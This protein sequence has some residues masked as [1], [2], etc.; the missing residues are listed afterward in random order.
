MRD[1]SLAEALRGILEDGTAAGAYTVADPAATAALLNAA[2]HAFDPG[3]NGS[4]AP[5]DR[6]LIT[7][8]QQLFRRAAG[9]TEP[10]TP[11]L[12][13]APWLRRPALRRLPVPG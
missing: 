1:A 3:F 7:A 10:S 12:R 5:A 8:A 4:H 9:I 6:Q 11:S 13:F 2:T